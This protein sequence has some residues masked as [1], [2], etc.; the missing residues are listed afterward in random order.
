MRGHD[1]QPTSRSGRPTVLLVRDAAQLKFDV[2][3]QRC[4]VYKKI[5]DLEASLRS[6]LDGLKGHLR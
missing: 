5:K 1:R 4:L 2:K 6:E 3:G